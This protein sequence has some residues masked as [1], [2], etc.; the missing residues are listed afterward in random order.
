[1]ASPGAAE[2]RDQIVKKRIHKERD[3][4]IASISEEQVCNLASSHRHGDRCQYF[5]APVR[6]SFNICFFVEFDDGAKWVVRIP[7]GPC[8]AAGAKSK[9]ESEIA[10]ML[11]VNLVPPN[12]ICMCHVFC[13]NKRRYTN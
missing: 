9:L 3:A 12:R 8:L 11:Y 10:T 5:K 4:F 7:L 13:S 1:M 6:G 2:R